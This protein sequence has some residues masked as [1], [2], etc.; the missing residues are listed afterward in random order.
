MAT[1]MSLDAAGQEL[2]S[3]IKGWRSSD[4]EVLDVGCE[5]SDD[6]DGIPSINLTVT[7]ADPPDAADTWPLDAILVLRRAVRERANELDLA[8]PFY[9]WLRPES[10]PPQDDS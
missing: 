5:V 9:L 7:L 4:V 2:A 8:A 3:V 1:T 10:D 6:R